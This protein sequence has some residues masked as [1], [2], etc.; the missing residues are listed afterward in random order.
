MTFLPF[1]M[2][3]IGINLRK[4]TKIKMINDIKGISKVI[5]VQITKICHTF[6]QPSYR[7]NI[8]STHFINSFKH[9]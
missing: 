2:I 9:S 7:K 8:L 6:V 3:W 4:Q 5:P 1:Y